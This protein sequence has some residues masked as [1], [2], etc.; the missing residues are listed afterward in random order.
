MKK[1]VVVVAAIVAVLAFAY[2]YQLTEIGEIGFRAIAFEDEEWISNLKSGKPDPDREYITPLFLNADDMLYERGGSLYAG[3]NRYKLVSGVPLFVNDTTAILNLNDAAKLITEDFERLDSYSGLL[4]SGGYSFN[5][6]NM[7]RADPDKFILVR[8]KSNVFSNVQELAVQPREGVVVYIP[9]SSVIYHT[10]DSISYY[11]YEETPDGG[12]RFVFNRI[13]GMSEDSLIFFE[14]DYLNYYDYLRKLGLMAEPK[15]AAPAAP[16]AS[17]EEEPTPEKE[18]APVIPPVA[19]IRPERPERPERPTPTPTPAPTPGEP[20]KPGVAPI[21]DLPDDGEGGA[22]PGE[23][24][25]PGAEADPP[26]DSGDKIGYREPAVNLSKMRV[27][28]DPPEQDSYK[29]AGRLSVIDKS[30][31]LTGQIIIYFTDL[32]GYPVKSE[33]IDIPAGVEEDWVYQEVTVEGLMLGVTYMAY[34][35]YTFTDRDGV[36]QTITFG[37]QEFIVE[38]PE[39][40][41]PDPAPPAPSEPSKPLPPGYVQ[42]KVTVTKD[43]TAKIYSIHGALDISDPASRIKG[44]VTFAIYDKNPGTL[45]DVKAGTLK[46][47][48]KVV[49]RVTVYNSGDFVLDPLEPDTEYWVVGTFDYMNPDDPPVR[50]RNYFYE[51]HSFMLQSRDGLTLVKATAGWDT[52]KLYPNRIAL[53]NFGAEPE[54]GTA[55]TPEEL[56]TETYTRTIE[57][58]FELNGKIVRTIKLSEAERTAFLAGKTDYL[59]STVFD[60]SQTYKYT[61]KFT[62]PF[63]VD[64]S[65]KYKPYPLDGTAATCKAPP[66]ANIALKVNKV[67]D[68]T[69]TINVTNINEALSH[70][71]IIKIYDVDVGTGKETLRS[72]TIM[73]GDNEVDGGTPAESFPLVIDSPGYTGGDVTFNFTDTLTYNTLPLGRAMRIVVYADYDIADGFDDDGNSEPNWQDNK[74]I[75]DISFVTAPISSLGNLVFDVRNLT[76][77]GD[78]YGARMDVSINTQSTDPLLCHL[79]HKVQLVFT[80]RIDGVK[81]KDEADQKAYTRTYTF[82][83]DP[84]D[85]DMAKNPFDWAELEKPEGTP[86]SNKIDN[87][88]GVWKLGAYRWATVQYK[89]WEAA[90]DHAAGAVV[91]FNGKFY[92]AQNAVTAGASDP[93]NNSAWTEIT[94]EWESE[95]P[96]YEGDFVLEGEAVYKALTDHTSG[97][98]RDDTAW[99]IDLTGK[100]KSNTQYDVTYLAWSAPMDQTPNSDE[101]P[102]SLRTDANVKNFKTLK[103]LPVV[104]RTGQFVTTDTIDVFNVWIDDPDGVCAY[105]ASNANKVQLMVSDKSDNKLVYGSTLYAGAEPAPQNVSLKN[106]KTDT[107]YEFKFYAVTYNQ[108]DDSRMAETQKELVNRTYNKADGTFTPVPAFYDPPAD[109]KPTNEDAPFIIRTREGLAGRVYLGG[110]TKSGEAYDAKFYVNLSDKLDEINKNGEGVFYLNIYRYQNNPDGSVTEVPV[111]STPHNWNAALES[112]IPSHDTYVGISA[113]DTTE[114]GLLAGWSYRVDLVVKIDKDFE[115]VLSQCE[116][117]TNSAMME[118]RDIEDF[119]L[120]YTSGYKTEYSEYMGREGRFVVTRDLVLDPIDYNAA[121]SAMTTYMRAYMKALTGETDNRSYNINGKPV[122]NIGNYSSATSVRY[123][124]DDGNRFEGIIDFQGFSLT[125]N[126]LRGSIFFYIGQ[127]GEI[128]NMVYN[129][130]MFSVE[131][132]SDQPRFAH[133]NSGWI[134]DVQFNVGQENPSEHVS[135]DTLKAR[136]YTTATSKTYNIGDVV[137]FSGRTYEAVAASGGAAD[138]IHLPTDTVYWKEAVLTGQSSSM[139]AHMFPESVAWNYYGAIIG[140]GNSGTIERFVVRVNQPVYVRERFGFVSSSNSG[141]I[142]DGYVYASPTMPATYTAPEFLYSADTVTYPG[143]QHVTPIPETAGGEVR[144]YAIQ[145]PIQTTRQYTSTAGGYDVG[146]VA[147]ANTVNGIIE[148]VYSSI[149]ILALYDGDVRSDLTRF[150]TVV[151]QNLGVVSGGYSTGQVAYRQSKAPW[152]AKGADTPR[153]DTTWYQSPI[154]NGYANAWYYPGVY[155]AI[156]PVTDAGGDVSTIAVTTTENGVPPDTNSLTP[157]PGKQTDVAYGPGVGSQGG[158]NKTSISYFSADDRNYTAAYNTKANIETLRA[159]N[160]QRLT[161]GSGFNVANTVMLGYYPH[162]IM[163]G[164]MP[165]Q[166]LVMLPLNTAEVSKV[167]VT[168]AIVEEQTDDY[169]VVA[170]TLQNKNVDVIYDVGFKG[171]TTGVSFVKAAVLGPN[172]T[173]SQNRLTAAGLTAAQFGTRRQIN[174]G[175]VTRL[176]IVVFDPLKPQENLSAERRRQDNANDRGAFLSRYTI[177]TVTYAQS[178]NVAKKA[179]PN[180]NFT[181]YAKFSQPISTL[182]DWVRYVATDFGASGTA[183]TQRNYR[184]AADIDFSEDELKKLTAASSAMLDKLKNEKIL[185]FNTTTNRGDTNTYSGAIGTV[186]TAGAVPEFRVGVYSGATSANQ[187][188]AGN[189]DGGK[190]NPDGELI[191]MYSLDKISAANKAG[192]TGGGGLFAFVTGKLSNFIVNDATIL[193]RASQYTGLMQSIYGGIVDNVHLYDETV[194]FTNPNVTYNTYIGGLVGFAQYSE[195]YNTSIEG[196]TLQTQSSF[197][198]AGGLAGSVVAGQL[199]ACYVTGI[200]ITADRGKAGYGIG[201]LLGYAEQGVSVNMYAEGNITTSDQYVGGAA[202]RLS[203]NQ[204]FQRTWN[205]VNV[206]TMADKAGGIAGGYTSANP[207]SVDSLALGNVMSNWSEYSKTDAAAF[208]HRGAGDRQYLTR[209]PAVIN[210]YA[211]EGQRINGIEI[212]VDNIAANALETDDMAALLYVGTGSIVGTDLKDLRNFNTY[213][214]AIKLGYGFSY[215]G[216]ALETDPYLPQVVNTHGDW[217]PQQPRITLPGAGALAVRIIASKGIPYKEGVNYLDGSDITMEYPDGTTPVGMTVSGVTVEIKEWGSASAAETPG[218]KRNNIVVAADDSKG[219]FTRY[220]DKYEITHVTLKMDGGEKTET[221]ATSGDMQF[222]YAKQLIIRSA[223]E[224][225]DAFDKPGTTGHGYSYENI[226]I[227]GNINFDELY[228]GDTGNGELATGA[229]PANGLLLNRLEG[230]DAATL[231]KISKFATFKNVAQF[232]F[233]STGDFNTFFDENPDFLVVGVTIELSGKLYRCSSITTVNQPMPASGT[234][235]G[236]QGTAAKGTWA[237]VDNTNNTRDGSGNLGGSL[238][239]VV[240][241]SVKNLEFDDF[242]FTTSG[243]SVGIIGRLAGTADN[244]KFK[245]ITIKKTS[246][247]TEYVGMFGAVNGA[248]SNV[249]MNNIYVEGYH[250]V[251]GL[252]GYSRNSSFDRI[253]AESVYVLSFSGAVIRTDVASPVYSAG[254]TYIGGILGYAYNSH[255]TGSNAHEIFVYGGSN[256]GGL[257]GYL[258]SAHAWGAVMQEGNNIQ[259][260]IVSVSRA[261]GIGSGQYGGAVGAGVMNE[262]GAEAMTTAR[263]RTTAEARSGDV[264]KLT[265][266]FNDQYYTAPKTDINAYNDNIAIIDHALVIGNAYTG[267]VAGSPSSGHVTRGMRVSNSMIFGT[268]YVGGIIGSAEGI[269][270]DYVRDSVISTV[271]CNEVLA[272]GIKGYDAWVADYMG[273]WNTTVKKLGSGGTAELKTFSGGGNSSAT[274]VGAGEN[275][276][277]LK[278]TD[279]IRPK[280]AATTDANYNKRIGGIN[281]QY[282]SGGVGIINSFVGSDTANEVGGIMGITYTYGRNHHY[283]INTVVRGRDYV[284]GFAGYMQN[285]FTTINAINADVKGRN[286]VGGITGYLDQNVAYYGTRTP[287]IRGSYF[288]GTIEATGKTLG[289]APEVADA[290]A[291]AAADVYAGG[292]SASQGGY[293]MSNDYRYV[294]NVNLVA[295]DIKV[296]ADGNA[297]F[298][299]HRARN[300]SGDT[301]NLPGQDQ[302]VYADSRTIVGGVETK[303]GGIDQAKYL[304]TAPVTTD[305]L[306]NAEWWATKMT[307]K[308]TSASIISFTNGYNTTENGKGTASNNNNYFHYRVQSNAGTPINTNAGISYMPYLTNYGAPAGSGTRIMTQQMGMADAYDFNKVNTY[309]DLSASPGTGVYTSPGYFAGIPIPTGTVGA[310]PIMGFKMLAMKLK[311]SPQ[312]L[313]VMTAA[314]GAGGASEL[315]IEFDGVSP[316]A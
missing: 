69:A 78:G 180:Q 1:V 205:K 47:G 206:L 133:S 80:P 237:E 7:T 233:A 227:D 143:E 267:G 22:P 150:G 129:T 192:E 113:W 232:T 46:N 94:D 241:A 139:P 118:I 24:P 13:E 183:R 126:T 90:A 14:N 244:L 272:E 289:L 100:L 17:P 58:E 177:D 67:A 242:A 23:E 173:E 83:A 6:D 315:N 175:G 209:G 30:Q 81:I 265:V 282:D 128:R 45:D 74:P 197:P 302:F 119:A 300:D 195:I 275:A 281:G 33:I 187:R 101:L 261:N 151:G 63:K 61:V 71:Y 212:R 31:L 307:S 62:D 20:E 95:K 4:V 120:I 292:I 271:F 264:A 217:M 251:G 56:Y 247:N 52:K 310:T 214:N 260:V 59:T 123:L 269:Y 84:D 305:N 311:A 110:L 54:N 156:K 171:E 115:K 36:T 169:A 37:E 222:Q 112:Y 108:G 165:A 211:W 240:T 138:K 234:D 221:V 127:H 268:A 155:Y 301:V 274:A 161:L 154:Q 236:S 216:I 164:A 284:G 263:D 104:R 253:E 299:Y 285:A 40:P 249:Y 25:L 43:L 159:E 167:Q 121:D 168:S 308:F 298:L 162:V 66:K 245:N 140:R 210:A 198:F 196:L 146:G 179:E 293:R 226:K 203:P 176:W 105:D 32:F 10:P 142:R 38:I 73:R 64:I 53:T 91:K 223:K 55:F 109:E 28:Y 178:A 231:K 277:G 29:A 200:A 248:I 144:R 199:D 99:H 313:P 250:Y 3:A 184:L 188:F 86:L 11:A 215:D 316:N 89:D 114:L 278:L 218:M 279:L 283:V 230:S 51:P 122:S 130:N 314:Y 42:P 254:G 213:Y 102:Y 96:Y 125:N 34:G 149:N 136:L 49:R 246:N 157:A 262:S 39:L 273:Y 9:L 131:G 141:V 26:V 220:F 145:V 106:L 35:E 16:E 276:Y 50:V 103:Q 287:Y 280:A 202:G 185:T 79:L 166:E 235:K 255:L 186:V 57:I 193:G 72:T 172:G 12:G 189:I 243:R 239:A 290:T 85:A 5:S 294:S 153:W 191:G 238:V 207:P 295:A 132:V 68:F 304:P 297:A 75:G 225:Q 259:D 181:V 270:N 208:V 312:P 87:D 60:S 224:W 229:L 219:D 182:A 82:A 44:G 70:N 107:N 152:R 8:M 286:Y 201:G 257:A 97:A 158:K 27:N 147:G 228:D 137:Y 194:T 88:F 148:N 116:F 124:G 2:F 19:P 190:Y 65:D 306:K 98:V 160:W 296:P 15:P 303:P 76:Q 134:H 174:S 21:E 117:D 266:Y 170:L 77:N 111:R 309:R 135:Y 256:L 163:D 92:T 93:G 258:H 18:P 252:A 288:V 204:T 41:T 291:P 48:A